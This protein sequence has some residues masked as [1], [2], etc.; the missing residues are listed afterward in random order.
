MKKYQNILFYSLIS[1]LLFWISYDVT[2]TYMKLRKEANSSLVNPPFHYESFA[3]ITSDIL[4]VGVDSGGNT[5]LNEVVSIS[6]SGLFIKSDDGSAYV[7]TVDHVCSYIEWFGAQELEEYDIDSL[8]SFMTITNFYGDKALGVAYVNSYSSDLCV[9]KTVGD[10]DEVEIANSLPELGEIIYYI[11]APRSLFFPGMV[12]S[13][14]GYLSGINY[15]KDDLYITAPA[16]QGA[17]GSI[18]VNSRGEIVGVIHSVTANFS[19]LT[20]ASG[21]KNI[22]ELLDQMEAKIK[23]ENQD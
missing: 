3:F 21:I 17:S 1:I 23:A 20:M 8:V 19:D 5:E 10:Y 11:G 13:F 4:E 16:A 7:L 18:V 9:I 12:P 6:G 2:Q 22:N 15:E 14:S